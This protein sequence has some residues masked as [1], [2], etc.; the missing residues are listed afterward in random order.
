MEAKL[1][2]TVLIP[3]RAFLR[4]S[5]DDSESRQLPVCEA[6]AS[7]SGLIVWIYFTHPSRRQTEVKRLF[8]KQL[9]TIKL[10]SGMWNVEGKSCL[11]LRVEPVGDRRRLTGARHE[12]HVTAPW[13][14]LPTVPQLLSTKLLPKPVEIGERKHC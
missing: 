14:R 9:G 2:I 8:H 12:A 11:S 5:Q 1:E 10:E 3:K 13:W 6:P 4:S 7:V